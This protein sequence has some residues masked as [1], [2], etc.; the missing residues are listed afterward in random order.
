MTH[1]DLRA[2]YQRYLAA[3]NA[4]EFDGMSEFVHETLTFNGGAISRNDYTGAIKG[5][6]ER[7]DGLAWH[8]E[9]IIV[10]GEHVSTRL[11]DT[12]T[13]VKEWL[14]LQPTGATVEF[15]EFCIYRFREG[16]IEQMWYLLDFQTIARQLAV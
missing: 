15:T 6:L 14:G 5:H 12:G 16:R 10:E 11:R 8:L 9:N 1:F 2:I 7:V 3:L 13:P 4:R